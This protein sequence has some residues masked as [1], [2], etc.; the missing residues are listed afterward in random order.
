MDHVKDLDFLPESIGVPLIDFKQGGDV[1]W[2][3]PDHGGHNVEDSLEGARRG[4]GTP[5]RWSS[6]Q[7][8]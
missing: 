7:S 5:V 8:W 1:I 2:F 6:Q 4:R 3:H